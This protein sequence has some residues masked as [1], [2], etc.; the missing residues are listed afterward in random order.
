MF[1]RTSRYASLPAKTYR[2]T[3]QYAGRRV[4][5]RLSGATPYVRYVVM[6]GDRL[7][8]IAA[9]YLGDP[10]QF[11]RIC[12]SNE[13]IVPADLVREPGGVVLISGPQR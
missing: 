2:G 5:P 7:D 8:T 13:V 9:R 12:D 6:Q 3:I 4:V 10:A 11:W 1:D